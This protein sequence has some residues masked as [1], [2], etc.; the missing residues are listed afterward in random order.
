MANFVYLVG[1]ADSEEAI[2]IDASWEEARIVEAARKD[3]KRLTAIVLTHAHYDH[4]QALPALVRNLGLP[5]FL[6]QAEMDF[7]KAWSAKHPSALGPFCHNFCALL[8]NAPEHFKPLQPDARLSLAGANMQMLLTPGH[9]VGSQCIWAE[10]GEG[11]LFTGDVLFVG[12]CGRTDLPG[13][14]IHQLHQSLH[15]KLQTLPGET[16]VFPGHDYGDAPVSSL[17]RER[18]HNPFLQDKESFFDLRS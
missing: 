1:A 3:K 2:L 15:V 11:A 8:E 4:V 5:V 12:A 18:S 17:A 13:G 10:G 16:Q 9:S 14:D 7:A 6:Q